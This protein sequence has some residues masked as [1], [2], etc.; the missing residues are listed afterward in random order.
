M[1]ARTVKQVAGALAAHMGADGY[2]R[3]GSARLAAELDLTQSTVERALSNLVANGWLIRDVT[4]CRTRRAV[5][6]AAVPDDARG[7]KDGAR[8]TQSAECMAH[9]PHNTAERMAHAPHNQAGTPGVLE[10]KT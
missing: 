1:S 3:P 10:P 5:Y 4:A 7:G 9:A 8:A 2:A 6:L